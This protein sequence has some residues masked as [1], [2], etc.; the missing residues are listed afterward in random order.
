MKTILISVGVVIALIVFVKVTGGSNTAGGEHVAATTFVSEKV[1][2]EMVVLDGGFVDL[3][4]IPI[5]GGDVDAAFRFKNTGSD[6]VSLVYGETSCMC[7]EAVVKKADGT[8]STRIQMP[9]H[10]S[11]GRMSMVVAAGETV[12]MIATFDP[13]AHGPNAL[14]PIMRD[15]IIQTNSKTTPE[16]RFSFRGV[17]VE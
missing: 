15:V 1:S 7:T 4:E 16:L 9:G 2:S 14:G 10:G 13:M 11:S 6:P 3:G 8:V 5:R 17:V 12:D